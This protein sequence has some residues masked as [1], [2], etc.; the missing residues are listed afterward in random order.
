ME[1][2]LI[3]NSQLSTDWYSFQTFHTLQGGLFQLLETVVIFHF[4]LGS[5]MYIL[6]FTLSIYSFFILFAK[7][8]WMMQS[9]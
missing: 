1:L 5:Q 9:N 7:L 4:F 8:S 2:N 3:L 6:G